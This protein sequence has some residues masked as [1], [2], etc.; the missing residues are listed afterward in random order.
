MDAF[1]RAEA[2]T[3]YAAETAG[4]VRCQLAETR[5]QVVFGSGDPGAE[6]MIVGELRP[7][8]CPRTPVANASPLDHPFFGSWQLAQLMVSSRDSRLSK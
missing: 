6:L 3:V 4:C 8:F 2:L 7:P 5:T 1:A